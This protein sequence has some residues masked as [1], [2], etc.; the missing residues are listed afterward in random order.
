MTENSYLKKEN[1]TFKA[2]I[3]KLIEENTHLHNELKN[4]TVHEILAEFEQMKHDNANGY[5]PSNN[6]TNDQLKSKEYSNFVLILFYLVGF[7]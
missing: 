7:I 2:H 1:S 6:Q 4:T 5:V 3:L